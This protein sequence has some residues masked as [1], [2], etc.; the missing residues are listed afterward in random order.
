MA[1]ICDQLQLRIRYQFRIAM[2]MFDRNEPVVI[3]PQNQR[4]NADTVK[5]ALELRIAAEGAP[6]EPGERRLVLIKLHYEIEIRVGREDLRRGSWIM[7]QR[8]DRFLRRHREEV[9]DRMLGNS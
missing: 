8:L 3:A 1:G 4:R 7:E 2:R 6:G 5:P 9:A